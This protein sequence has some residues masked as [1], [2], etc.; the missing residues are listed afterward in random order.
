MR[1]SIK[2]GEYKTRIIPGVYIFK[3]TSI[4]RLKAY[5]PN[6]GHISELPKTWHAIQVEK[7]YTSEFPKFQVHKPC[8]SQD[9]CTQK[10]VILFS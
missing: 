1:D 5:Q 10:C 6:F 7:D 2:V 9:I 8:G 3:L 4:I